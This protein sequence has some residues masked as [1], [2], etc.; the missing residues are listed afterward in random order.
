MAIFL[1]I[2]FYFSFFFNYKSFLVYINSF[3]YS[4]KGPGKSVNNSGSTSQFFLWEKSTL[5]QMQISTR[6]IEYNL[7]NG[8]NTEKGRLKR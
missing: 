7:E 1:F 8:T 4:I 6:L 5:T 2:T 3:D